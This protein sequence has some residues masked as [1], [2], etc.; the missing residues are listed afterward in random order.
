MA[1]EFCTC[2]GQRTDDR[3]FSWVIRGLGED[4]VV[5][6]VESVPTE[7]IGDRSPV[8]AGEEE[9]EYNIYHTGPDDALYAVPGEGFIFP[10]SPQNKDGKPIPQPWEL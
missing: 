8:S 7:E 10:D 6:R 5:L 9:W 4:V 2:V 1:K 3:N